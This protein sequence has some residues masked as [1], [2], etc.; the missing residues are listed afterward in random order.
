M[1]AIRKRRT[2]IWKYV[3]CSIL[4][5]CLAITGW[6]PLIGHVNAEQAS[7]NLLVNP[8]FEQLAEEGDA[9]PGWALYRGADNSVKPGIAAETTDESSSSGAYSLMVKD[10]NT[11]AAIVVYSDLIEVTP[12]Q[13]YKLDMKANQVSGTIYTAVRFYKKATDNPIS[14]FIAKPA[15]AAL[16]P[17]LIW[18]NVN[19]EAPA[20]ADAAYARI[21]VYTTSATKGAALV[22]DLYFSVKQ[23]IPSEII[24]FDITNLGPQVHTVN[25]HRAAL[26]KDAA[27]NPVAYSTMVGIPAKLLVIDVKSEKL[28]AAIPIE[29]TVNGTNY[30]CTYV[31]GLSVQPDGTVYMAGTPNNLFKYVPGASKVEFV[32]KVSGS[33]VFDMKNGPDGT[34]IGGTYNKSEG[35]EFN[36]NTKVNTN[37]GPS[38]AGESYSYSVA[39]DEKRNDTYFGIGAHA[40]LIKYDRDTK[41]KT[42]IPLPERYQSSQFIYDMT[43]SGDKL[44]M[45]F[46]PGL[47]IA[48]DLNTMQFDETE[49]N[50]TSRH[51]SPK[52]PSDNK[53]Y[54]TSDSQ[55]G[56]YDTVSQ[57][58]VM[59]D[60]DTQG[61]MN[62]FG[63]AQLEDPEYPGDTLIGVTRYGKL[64][65]YNPATGKNKSILFEIAG[66]PTEL[67]TVEVSADG[68]VHT[69]GYLSGGN[70]IYN[71]FTGLTQEFTNETLGDGQKLP[72][73]QTDRIYHYN[74]K[75]YYVN[76]TNMVVYEFDPAKPW[77]RLDPVSP[78]PRELFTA[79]DVG[80]Q[81]RGLAGIMIDDG[82]LAIGTVPKYGY[83]GGALAIYD[84]K[85]DQ[86]EVYWNIVNQQS[87]TA[88]TYKDGL[89]YGGSNIY[90]GLGADPT[91]T[92]AKLFIWDV[93][94]KQ[95]VFEITPVPGKKGIT[96][97]IVGPDGMIWGS[98][99]GYL[100]IFNPTTRQ[101]VHTQ[102]LMSRNYSSAVWR[103]AQFEVG[104]DGHVYGVQANQFFV[105]NAQTKVK[106]V[107]RNVGIRNW[108]SQDAFGNFYLTEGA[109]LL[110]L[111]IPN[112][113]LQ[114]TGA[115]LTLSANRLIRNQSAEPMIKALLSQGRSITHLEQRSPVYVSSNPDVIAIENGK[116]IAG[117]PGTAEVWAQVNVGGSTL[118]TNRV[119]I[120]VTATM[121]SLENEVNHYIQSGAIEN[122]KSQVLLNTLSQVRH[123]M[124]KGDSKQAAK[125]LD[126]FIKH[127]TSNDQN[128]RIADSIVQILVAD[129]NAVS[130]ALGT[131]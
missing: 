80:H 126:D 107:I 16:S 116:F 1:S 10:D 69:S 43:V 61:D 38:M 15:L 32:S 130:A 9:I 18:K 67:Q 21:L 70:S 119:T 82:K 34:L 79:S 106:K 128:D 51:V 39:Y 66:E 36:T 65:K 33:Q 125:K 108:I 19:L 117:N 30:S 99:E 4:A 25:T 86:R 131:N 26:G 20:P 123:F 60:V 13:A 6:A 74:D 41:L 59:L 81:D 100:F 101:I 94:A 73:S 5:I 102:E 122:G 45:R 14:G 87:V 68:M 75:I 96:E 103:D 24:P 92:E 127:V 97:L 88:V 104:T 47:T 42:E 71:P 118:V 121:D 52:A 48:M 93:K 84:L 55:L 23:E 12:N 115:E 44:F 112:L 53:I 27:G 46:S 54:F 78:N 17:T 40:H 110:K 7:P 8:G 95:K 57:Q 28:I 29:D 3:L 83:L 58:Y 49:G 124:D 11:T 37:L 56:Y 35:F 98:A 105:I 50:V 120:T 72:G 114:A 89:I 63:F 85:T 62:G 113:I 2:R 109:E 22:D 31:R 129:A 77:N 76:Y 64:F 91:E 90:G 111:T